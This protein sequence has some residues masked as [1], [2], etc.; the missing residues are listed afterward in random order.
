LSYEQY[1]HQIKHGEI[2]DHELLDYV[3]E[4]RPHYKTAL[5]SNIS[6]RGLER[7]FREGELEQ[8][9]DVTVASGAIGHAKPEPEAY[10]AVTEKLGVTPGECIFIDD[11]ER[12]CDAAEALGM[13]AIYYEKFASFKQEL[14]RLLNETA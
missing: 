2:K 7:R 9:F 4:L 6:H 3:K 8:Y 5:L 1:Q 12:Y 10:L 14:T 11:I 13:R